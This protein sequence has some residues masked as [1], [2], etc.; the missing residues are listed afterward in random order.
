[1]PGL[2]PVQARPKPVAFRPSRAWHNTRLITAIIDHDGLG[3]A[4]H[5]ISNLGET[6]QVVRLVL[7]FVD[8]FIGDLVI[9]S[10]IRRVWLVWERNPSG[11]PSL[12]YVMIYCQ[13]SVICHDILP[14]Y[15]NIPCVK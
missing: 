13:Y 4:A 9:V 12:G 3:S 8:M 2:K 14:I 11:K 6:M 1:M 15:C 5:F 7:L 10:N